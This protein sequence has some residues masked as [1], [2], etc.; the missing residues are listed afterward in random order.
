MKDQE[1]QDYVVEMRRHFHKYPEIGLKEVKTSETIQA[2]LEKIGYEVK[3]FEKCPTGIMTEIRGRKQGNKVVALRADIDA[4][5]IQEESGESFSS[6]HPGIMHACGHDAHI[7]MLLGA[8]R[9]LAEEID[10][11]GGTI[12]LLFEPAEEFDGAGK[13]M[14]MEGAMENADTTF[15]IHVGEGIPV[16]KIRI[17]NGVCMAGAG[18]FSLTVKGK[19]G[20]GS[21]PDGG[22]DVIPAA[23]A[24]V[25]NLQTIVSREISP[26]DSAV[27]SVGTFHA[28]K[29]A[30][31]IADEAKLTGSLRYFNKEVQEKL[32]DS[33]RRIVESTASAYRVQTE[34]HCQCALPPAI[35]DLECSHLAEECALSLM[36]KDCLSTGKPST[37]S[38]DFAYYL[39]EAPGVYA[40]LG[41]GQEAAEEHHPAHSSGFKIDESTLYLGARMYAEY[42]LRYLK[43]RNSDE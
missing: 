41:V 13:Q 8:A 20:H 10:N 22:I 36:G 12:R 31:I 16:G 30:N 40:F 9:L 21:A 14:I 25:M 26:I 1:L 37:G 23:S 18:F 4:L 15:A 42:A 11:F 24:M 19:G 33:V 6:V 2:E 39:E 34:L 32:P 17:H 7:A 35:N 43:G 29:Q 5:P 27:V 3:R 38:D 28:G